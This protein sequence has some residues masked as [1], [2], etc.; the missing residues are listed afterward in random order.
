MTSENLAYILTQV[1]GR[2][3]NNFF[4][5]LRRS[6]SILE[7]PL[8]TA[9]GEGKSYIYSNYNPKYAQYLTTIFRTVYNF[10]SPRKIGGAWLTPAQQLGITDKVYE[11]KDI[12]Y[13]V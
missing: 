9:R 13:F 12:I 10:C 6:V 11:Y 5:E 7:R 8:V 3:I 4:Q 2:T 1:N